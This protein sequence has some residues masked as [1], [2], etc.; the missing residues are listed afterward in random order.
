MDI[1]LN[2]NIEIVVYKVLIEQYHLRLVSKYKMNN[3]QVVRDEPIILTN[4]PNQNPHPFFYRII[5]FFM[6]I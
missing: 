5:I 1:Q 6:S 3:G 2:N 4:I